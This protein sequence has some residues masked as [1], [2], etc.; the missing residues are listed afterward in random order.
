[1]RLVELAQVCDICLAKN[2]TKKELTEQVKKIKAEADAEVT[3]LIDAWIASRKMNKPDARLTRA[4]IEVAA[5][6]EWMRRAANSLVG[7]A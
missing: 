2:V 7:G 4:S 1:M 3:R 6:P 5:W